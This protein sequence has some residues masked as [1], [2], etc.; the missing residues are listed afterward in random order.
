MSSV[1]TSYQ[2]IFTAFKSA[3]AAEISDKWATGNMRKSDASNDR[4]Q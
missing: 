4:L 3:F 2:A 1:K